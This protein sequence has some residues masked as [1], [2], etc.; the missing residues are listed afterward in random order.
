[1]CFSASVVVVVIVSMGVTLTKT[2]K[3][4]ASHAIS[5]P[6]IW[7][8]LQTE[9]CNFSFHDTISPCSDPFWLCFE[10]YSSHSHDVASWII[11]WLSHKSENNLMARIQMPS[12][13][14]MPCLNSGWT[15][16]IIIHKWNI[17][18]L[19]I[20]L[21]NIWRTYN[22]RVTQQGKAR[23]YKITRNGESDGP[24]SVIEKMNAEI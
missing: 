15:A 1:M 12:A 18:I 8:N 2:F 13:G 14:G 9:M 23:Q 17:S 3:I 11:H 10:T 20:N 21:A 16:I 19:T 5:V 6:S 7:D 22:K 24:N 4:H